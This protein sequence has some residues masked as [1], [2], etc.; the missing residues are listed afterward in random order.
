[1]NEA[2]LNRIPFGRVSQK[3]CGEVTV[4]LISEVARYIIGQ[5]MMVDGVSV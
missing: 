1:M 4:F 3:K 2:T 5:I